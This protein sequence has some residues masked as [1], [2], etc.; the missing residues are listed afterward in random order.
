MRPITMGLLVAAG[1]ALLA[2]ASGKGTSQPDAGV[3]T[4]AN[5]TVPGGAADESGYSRLTEINPGNIGRLGLAWSLDLPDEVT[6]ESTPLAIDGV[7]YFSGGYAEVYAVEATTGKLRWK[8]D[9]QTWKRRPDKFHYG[10]NRG[11]AYED[12]RIFTVEMDRY[13]TRL[14]RVLA[15]VGVICRKEDAGAKCA[16]TGFEKL[17]TAKY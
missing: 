4:E 8:F 11:I 10:A 7:L 3:G 9:P 2:A 12:G 13:V 15:S 1:A 5:W 14:V 16:R 17:V 6:L